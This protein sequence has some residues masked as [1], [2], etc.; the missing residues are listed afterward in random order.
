MRFRPF[1]AA[2]DRL[3]SEGVGVTLVADILTRCRSRIVGEGGKEGKKE[4]KV[5]AHFSFF[6]YFLLQ[7]NQQ[8][9]VQYKSLSQKKKAVVQMLEGSVLARRLHKLLLFPSW[10]SFLCIYNFFFV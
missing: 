10:H 6:Y 7:F 8:V 9:C 2:G 5:S 4:I 1:V 3:S